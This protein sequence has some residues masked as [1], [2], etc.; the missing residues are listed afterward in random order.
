MIDQGKKNVLG[1]NVDAVDYEAALSR[2]SDAAHQQRE[3]C[4]SALAVH[5][6]MT[7]VQ[8][9]Q[10]KHRL[11]A[12]HLVVPDGQPVRWA[13]NLLHRTH[14]KSR[15]YGPELTQRTI[16]MA[17]EQGLPVYFYGST[18]EILEGMVNRLR[19]IHPQLQV[20]GVEPSKFRS[21]SP[22]ECTDLGD[23]ITAS[24]ARILFVGLGCPRQEVFAY[25]MQNLVSMPVIAVGAAFAFLSGQLAQAPPR[26]QRLGLEWLFRLR[27]EPKRLWRRYVYLNPYYMV[28]LAG[29]WLGFTFK[30]QGVPPVTSLRHG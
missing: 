5:G 30:T 16:A 1:I 27:E 12:F 28:L 23:R 15:V 9:A 2:I 14:L 10:H 8:S 13:L 21:L 24:G 19:Q 11:N 18:P 7:G 25:E 22:A 6:V 29:Q 4:V 3:Y 20:A 17:E 26:L